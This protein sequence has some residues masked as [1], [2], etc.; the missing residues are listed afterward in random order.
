MANYRTVTR[1]TDTG[2]YVIKLILD[3]GHEAGRNDLCPDSFHVHA[4]RY[5]K[6]GTILMRRERGAEK[7]LPSLGTVKVRDAYPSNAD[8]IKQTRG[9]YVVLELEEER[10]NKRIEGSVL[11]SRY[12]DNTY[13]VTLTRDLPPL[14]EGEAPLSGLVFDHCTGDL[15]P[16]LEGWSNGQNTLQY[17]YYT[18]RAGAEQKLPLLVWLHGAGEGGDDPL[19]AYTGNRVTALSS[20]EIQ[21]K[22]G[23]AAW[24]LVPQC[25]TVWMDNGREKLERVNESI[26]VQPLKDCIDDFVA[27]HADSIDVDRIW[28][29]GVSNGGFM[30]IRMLAEY[31]G[32]FAGAAPGCEAF[33][34]ENLSENVLQSVQQTPLWLVHAKGDELVDPAQTS[35]PLYHRL[36]ER[37]MENL[38]MTY[39]DE[40][41]DPTGRYHEADGRPRSYFRHGVWILMLDDVCREDLDGRRVLYH[42][43]PVT[44]WEWLGKQHR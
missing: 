32:F 7:A 14:Q 5:E 12:I 36:K 18:P 23:G 1:M 29:S 41:V 44:L 21:K 4:V 15:C 24:I 40:V 42:G 13:R 2:P 20:P 9:S 22:L 16:E 38:H 31:P 35:L 34:E 3:L 17:G 8:G 30:T 26:Y 28:V 39:W 11:A 27:Q 37:G 43:E 33:F 6:D 19:V 25:P 10:L